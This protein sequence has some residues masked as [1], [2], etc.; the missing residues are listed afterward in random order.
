[1]HKTNCS[2]TFAIRQSFFATALDDSKL[3]RL[4]SRGPEAHKKSDNHLTGVA[5]LGVVNP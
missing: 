1:M 4:Q 5:F 3:P 2:N